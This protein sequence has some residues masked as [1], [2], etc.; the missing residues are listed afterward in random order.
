[1]ASKRKIAAT[2]RAA[3]KRIEKDGWCQ[4]ACEAGTA[5]C[6]GYALDTTLPYDYDVIDAAKDFFSS[7]LKLPSRKSG[8]T[9]ALITWNDRKRRRKGEV[10]TKLREAARAIEA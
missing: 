10:V 2:L 8:A 9:N 1:M 4:G 3:A 6:V 7:H 5:V